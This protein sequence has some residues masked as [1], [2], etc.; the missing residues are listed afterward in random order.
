[1]M[2]KRV[3][4]FVCAILAVCAFG[5]DDET[6]VFIRVGTDSRGQPNMIL[7][8]I[9]AD[10]GQRNVIFDS[11]IQE[12]VETRGYDDQPIPFPKVQ[13]SPDISVL[14]KK[15]VLRRSWTI[16]VM[17]WDG[18][19]AVNV[20]PYGREW[21][22]PRWSPDGR[23]IALCADKRDVSEIFVMDH[24]GANL[25]NLTWKG[26]SNERSPDWSPD[27][28]KMVF[29]S[30]RNGQFELFTMNAMNGMDQT[31]ILSLDG[32]IREP[33]WG[34]H[35]R[36]AFSLQKP[37][38]SAAIFS[39]DPN[40][41]NVTQ[42]T[43]GTSW[44]GHV[45]WDA[46]G[47]RLAFASNRSGTSDMWVLDV[48]SKA[49]RNVTNNVEENEF[50]PV[51]VPKQLG[52][53][54]LA[55]AATNG[56]AANIAG[57][58]LPRPRLLFRA[59][60]LPSIRAMVGQE[61]HASV[62]KAF[63]GS[64]DALL[65]SESGASKKV[66]AS[67]ASIEGNP[68]RGLYDRSNWI[69]PVFHLAFARQ[70]TGERRY[71]ERAAAWLVRIAKEYA[72]WHQGMVHEYPVACAYD[73]LYDL[74][75]PDDLKVLTGL[76]QTDAARAYKSIND[77]YFGETNLIAS[78]FA[79]HAAGSVGPLM[80]ALSGEP[81]SRAEW[82]SAAARLTSINLN[83][84]IGESGDASEGTSY[85]NYPINLLTPFLVSLKI[86]E[87]HP[88]TWNSNLRKFADWYA[89]VNAG[90]MLP[91]LGDSDGGPISFP[92]GLLQL[93]PDNQTA[94]KLW[95]SVPRAEK[96]SASV[97]SLL[98]FEPSENQP[99]D[100]TGFPKAAYFD[101]QNYQVFRTGYS[102]DSL[103]LTF[104]LTAGGHAHLECGAVSLHGFGQKLLVDPGQ[105]VSAAD[106]HSQLLING[107]GRFLNYQPANAPRQRISPIQSEALAAGAAVNMA[108]AFATR[109]VGSH[110][111]AGYS[112]PAPGMKLEHGSR[113]VLMVGEDTSVAPP[114]YLVYDD[115]RVNERESQYE[116]L[117]IGN[118]DMIPRD[119]GE[120][121][122]VF[123]KR[124]AGA[125][126]APVDN[127]KGEASLEFDVET[128]GNYQVWVYM[129]R[130]PESGRTGNFAFRLGESTYNALAAFRSN[131]AA[132]WQW[133]A[134]IF[135]EGGHADHAATRRRVSGE[136]VVSTVSLAAGKQTLRVLPRNTIF[137]KIALIPED[138][139]AV[140]NG[141]GELPS[142]ALAR[143]HT[144]A[145]I[146]GDAWKRHSSERPPAELLVAS[147]NL[148]PAIFA[149][150]SFSF[151]TR[152]HGQQFIT[153]PRGRLIKRQA[154]SNFLTLLYAYLPGMEQ[155]AI[156][157]E[158]NGAVIRWEHAVD[159]VTTT[160]T[161]ILVRRERDD[162]KQEVFR[163]K[164]PQ[165]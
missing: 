117:Y 116:Q 66:E 75:K 54:P 64:C 103:L 16:S 80:L 18:S 85:F 17:N 122:F 98:W 77:R 4:T 123:G 95:N 82:L 138:E 5:V 113:A 28:K 9:Q 38:G 92:Q 52:D 156:R 154:A 55:V 165:W 20:T 81:G 159:T 120:G 118:A 144:D 37:D 141:W 140:F 121:A 49:L 86:N 56:A 53:E 11:D 157:R 6:I 3:M 139:A 27:G 127:A 93:Y 2:T 58:E 61:P 60:D 71:G 163:Y 62:W 47:K 43:D 25:R 96:P 87:L 44:D 13:R 145:V 104:S 158:K 8:R 46:A 105:A 153:L 79:T 48:D 23:R 106:C 136:P 90:G 73:W 137:A 146:T 130:N 115:V 160:E 152:F 133:G 51:W 162:G 41:E 124:Y 83:T 39:V 72:K 89:I 108:P 33:D 107:E 63:L 155:P 128:P 12:T 101:S 150:D 57:V 74:F 97:L 119:N 126:L 125:W 88:E 68:S 50:F 1:M 40:G 110:N 21:Y 131:R 15:I 100:Y 31:R 151:N 29:I 84:W 164:R 78:N 19:G 14:G 109:Q 132:C 76:L 102:D 91:A 30:D 69:E 26:K 114:Y 65:D 94:R 67:I 142:G 134:V 135:R 35:G 129:K 112:I 22:D 149:Q 143:S 32:D 148:E 7:E 111:G 42:L 45:A 59:E 24:D 34:P 161:E 10:G 99:Q 147:L 36:I 70:V